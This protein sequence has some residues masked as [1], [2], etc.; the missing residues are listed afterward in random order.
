[1]LARPWRKVSPVGSPWKHYNKMFEFS[2]I[3]YNIL[4]Q[5]LL[6]QNRYLYRNIKEEY[7]KTNRI[8]KIMHELDQ[9]ESDVS[10]KLLNSYFVSLK[11]INSL[12]KLCFFSDCVSARV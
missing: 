10:L 2:I 6:D 9:Y 5:L 11:M 3:S 12:P 1:M 7:L 8:Y 4:S